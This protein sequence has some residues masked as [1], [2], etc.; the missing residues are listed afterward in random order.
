MVS[1]TTKRPTDPIAVRLVL[2]MNEETRKFA[3]RL[4]RSTAVGVAHVAAGAD[5]GEQVVD[6]GRVGAAR[7]R[8]HGPRPV[9]VTDGVAAAVHQ[10]QRDHGDA[11]VARRL[12]PVVQVDVRAGHAAGRV[13]LGRPSSETIKQT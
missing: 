9:D 3:T 2:E 10:R 12:R 11:A 5:E 13:V 7:A 1:F 6:V 8:R 4:A